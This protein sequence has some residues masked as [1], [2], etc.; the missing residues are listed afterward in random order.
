MLLGYVLI[1]F[2]G[3]LGSMARAWATLA[4]ARVAGATFPWGTILIN[5]LGSF[6]IGFF[7][8]LTDGIGGRFAATAEARAFIMIGMCGGFTTFSSF[9]LQ[10]LELLRHGRT[11]PAVANIGLSVTLCLAAV[12][13]GHYGAAA[14][15]RR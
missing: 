9:S 5:I 14:L 13:A 12:A 10:T 4:M 3:A 8:T 2:G 11:G 15:G 7:G 6:V 1:G